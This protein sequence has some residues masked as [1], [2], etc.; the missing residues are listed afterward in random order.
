MNIQVNININFTKLLVLLTLLASVYVS[1]ELENAGV[2]IATVPS[3]AV[4]LGVRDYS[5]SR[6]KQNNVKV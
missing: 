2:F 3:L 1:I 4:I 6:K 5:D